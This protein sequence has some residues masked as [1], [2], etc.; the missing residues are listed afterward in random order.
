MS[1]FISCEYPVELNPTLK[2]ILGRPNF[3]CGG[4]AGAL[5]KKGHVISQNAEEEQAAVIH[6]TLCLYLEFGDNWKK[7]A[8]IYLE[9]KTN[10]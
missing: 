5:R 4:L 7:V 10:G 2:E 6:W 8:K 1:E 9:E 3:G